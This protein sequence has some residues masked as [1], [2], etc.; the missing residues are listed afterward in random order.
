MPDLRWELEERRCLGVWRFHGN[1]KQVLVTGDFM[2]VKQQE[3][4]PKS[5]TNGWYKL[6]KRDEIEPCYD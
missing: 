2:L 6:S 4:I 5:V 3:T 1:G